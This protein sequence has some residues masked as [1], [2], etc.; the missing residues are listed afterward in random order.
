MEE[1]MSGAGKWYKNLVF[2]K[3]VFLSHLAVSL[4][5][6]VIL[7]VFCYLQTRSLLI[8]REREVLRETL[9]QTVLRMDASLENYQHVMENLVWDV[10]IGK[11]LDQQYISRLFWYC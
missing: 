7:G 3:K 2:R 10:N 5:P 8:R 11:A 4:I 6:V 1:K 9:E